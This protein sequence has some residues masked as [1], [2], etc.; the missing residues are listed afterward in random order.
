MQDLVAAPKSFF[1]SLRYTMNW[2]KCSSNNTSIST[3]SHAFKYFL[4]LCARFHVEVQYPRSTLSAMHA[5]PTWA[6]SHSLIKK[7]CGPSHA[8]VVDAEVHR[9]CVSQ[10]MQGISEVK[11]IATPVE[12][13]R[14]PHYLRAP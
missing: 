6:I 8:V 7:N 12:N 3:G 9:A 1:L 14:E 13:V 4:M 5:S 10:V 2:N 11:V